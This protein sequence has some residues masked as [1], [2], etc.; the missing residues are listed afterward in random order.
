[1]HI[2]AT[3]KAVAHY[4]GNEL[5]YQTKKAGEEH[6]RVWEEISL[7]GHAAND[8]STAATP[9]R[10]A[11]GL[12]DIIDTNV[13]SVSGGVLT[14]PE[15]RDFVADCFR[16]RVNGAAGGSKLLLASRAL[17]LTIDSWGENKLQLNAAAKQTYGMDVLTYIG[18]TGT[19][20]VVFHPLLESG[21]EDR[22]YLIDPD[23]CMFR[24]LRST[25][26]RMDIE[27]DGEDGTKHEYITEATFQYAQEKCFG[28]IDGVTY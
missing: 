27:E 15:F 9:I 1:V 19:L 18:S 3:N 28:M 21:Y 2:T 24:P 8:V 25:K 14:E 20:N 13:L 7:H 5:D 4:H 12:D 22:S 17:K 11:G 23:G 16:Y 26:L 10:T 6:A